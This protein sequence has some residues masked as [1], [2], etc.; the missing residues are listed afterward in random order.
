MLKKFCVLSWILFF[1]GER[2]TQATCWFVWVRLCVLK[3]HSLKSSNI[4]V[5]FSHSIVPIFVFTRCYCFNFHHENLIKQ[6]KRMGFLVVIGRCFFLKFNFEI[7]LL[8]LSHC[9]FRIVC[10]LSNFR[11]NHF[12]WLKLCTSSEYVQ[13]SYWTFRHNVVLP[14]PYLSKSINLWI[15]KLLFVISMNV[16]GNV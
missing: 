11:E 8:W 15:I 4:S 13:H 7:W 16:Y 6:F 5:Y 2:K 14:N 3:S 9:C 12:Y 1:F 10:R